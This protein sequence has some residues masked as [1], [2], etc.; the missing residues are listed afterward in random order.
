MSWLER[1]AKPHVCVM[2]RPERGERVETGDVWRCDA[3]GICHRVTVR[4]MA[5]QREPDAP[6]L[7][8][9]ERLGRTRSLDGTWSG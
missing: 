4:I 3:C 7:F 8:S 6:P 2:P 9:W 1:A 5:D